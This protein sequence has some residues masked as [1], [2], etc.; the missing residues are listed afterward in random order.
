MGDP[1]TNRRYSCLWAKTVR[2][3]ES[4]PDTVACN[5]FKVGDDGGGTGGGHSKLMK[6]VVVVAVVLGVVNQN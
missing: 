3:P 4:V 5:V 2:G 6:S 1:R